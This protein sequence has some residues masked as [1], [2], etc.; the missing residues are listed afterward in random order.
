M[1]ILLSILLYIR[2]FY[3]HKNPIILVMKSKVSDPAP[4]AFARVHADFPLPAGLASNML[5]SS[6]GIATLSLG[7]TSPQVPA[8]D[9]R[10]KRTAP[11]ASK[12]SEP[13]VID[14]R[15]DTPACEVVVVQDVSK[16][17]DWLQRC[18]PVYL[19]VKRFEWGVIEVAHT[20]K[21]NIENIFEFDYFR[22]L[23]TVDSIG[24]KTYC[25]RMREDRAIFSKV[26]VFRDSELNFDILK[27]LEILQKTI[28]CKSDHVCEVIQHEYIG[29]LFLTTQ[30]T[31]FGNRLKHADD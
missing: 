12:R 17:R 23:L 4:V 20:L 16:V 8:A 29:P 31:P 1:T 27:R 15:A 25:T 26:N 3:L 2:Q 6:L 21:K 22:Y 9:D 24:S 28:V 11:G 5:R 14:H 10:P 30:S 13:V 7:P 18:W 19:T